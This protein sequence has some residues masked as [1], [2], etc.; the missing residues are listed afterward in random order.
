M[1]LIKIEQ[2]MRDAAAKFNDALKKN[3]AKSMQAAKNQLN[4]LKKEY[5]HQSQL[6]I[7]SECAKTANPYKRAAEIL[8]YK[9]IRA[10]EEREDGI[11]MGMTVEPGNPATLDI[12]ALCKYCEKDHL[13]QYDVA[14]LSYLV[15]LNV[16]KG[17]SL[18]AEAIRDIKGKFLMKDAARKVDMGIDP[19]SNNQLVKGLQ[20]IIDK[21][22][23]ENVEAADDQK[24]KAL[25]CDIKYLKHGYVKADH[26][27]TE[28]SVK[29]AQDVK[30]FTKY[31]LTVMNRLLTNGNYSIDFKKVKNAGDVSEGPESKKISKSED[32]K[33]TKVAP[34]AKKGG[35]KTEKAEVVERPTTTTEA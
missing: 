25:V 11:T 32:A 17:L 30:V 22:L 4:D 2:A 20:A 34:T 28:V 3:D 14:Q 35:K 23:P 24:L 29:K 6:D 13:W 15:C 12:V 33:S 10:T 5:N 26:G 21:L 19:S 7:F 1:E 9:T 31:I 27:S 18:P 8:T 16:A